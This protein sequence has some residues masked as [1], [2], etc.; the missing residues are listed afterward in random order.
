MKP[1]ENK[2][3]KYIRNVDSI[4]TNIKQNG[5]GDIKSMMDSLHA[6][7]VTVGDCYGK[8]SESLSKRQ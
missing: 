4:T 2:L 1:L 3:I 7:L 5:H 8:I 6:I